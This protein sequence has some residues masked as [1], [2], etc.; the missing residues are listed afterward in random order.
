MFGQVSMDEMLML[1]G[2]RSLQGDLLIGACTVLG[3]VGGG[4][5]FGLSGAS[6]GSSVP[7]IGTAFGGTIGAIGGAVSGGLAGAEVG[8]TLADYYGF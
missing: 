1:D 6:I 7:G 3:A 8:V 4:I 2:G 5:S